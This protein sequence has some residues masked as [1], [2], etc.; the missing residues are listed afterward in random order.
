MSSLAARRR[1]YRLSS[2]R[3][4]SPAVLVRRRRVIVPIGRRPLHALPP[5][6]AYFRLAHA[7]AAAEQLI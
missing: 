7:A 3:R 2:R 6:A 1:L 4:P 5:L